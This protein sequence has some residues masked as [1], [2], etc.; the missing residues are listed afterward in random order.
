MKAM[1]KVKK[2]KVHNLYMKNKN[3]LMNKDAG[4]KD[5]VRLLSFTRGQCNNKFVL[6]KEKNHLRWRFKLLRKFFRV[7]LKKIWVKK[8]VKNCKQLQLLSWI[9]SLCRLWSKLLCQILLLLPS[10]HILF[11][12]SQKLGK[13]KVTRRKRVFPL[14]KQKLNSFYK[15]WSSILKGRSRMYLKTCKFRQ[16][17]LLLK[18]WD[19]CTNTNHKRYSLSKEKK[20]SRM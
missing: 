9:T 4:W 13:L 20:M 18:C 14:V 1:K 3:Y 6:K 17:H 15:V 19:T 12:W 11:L 5:H 10:R 8:I 16:V 7:I 2:R